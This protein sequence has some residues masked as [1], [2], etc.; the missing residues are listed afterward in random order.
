MYLGMF[1]TTY[2]SFIKIHGVTHS[3]HFSKS[4]FIYVFFFLPLG[5]NKSPY[6]VRLRD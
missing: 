5:I 1:Y 2:T 6:G 3:Y 4:M